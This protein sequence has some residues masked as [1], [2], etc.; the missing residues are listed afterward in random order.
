MWGSQLKK[1]CQ[2]VICIT[3][4]SQKLTHHWRLSSSFVAHC[5]YYKLLTDITHYSLIMINTSFL[6]CDKKTSPSCWL[7][8][9]DTCS[10]HGDFDDWQKWR[11]RNMSHMIL[12]LSFLRKF[13]FSWIEQNATEFF[14]EFKKRSLIYFLVAFQQKSQQDLS[15]NNTNHVVPWRHQTL[16]R[17]LF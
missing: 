4:K 5:V 2:C 17:I 1:W 6:L 10:Q 11:K 8:T 9:I 7:S 15:S 16:L 13:I 3:E 14:L 12:S